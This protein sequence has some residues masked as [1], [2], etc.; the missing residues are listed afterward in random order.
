MARVIQP[1]LGKGAWLWQWPY[2]SVAAA[3]GLEAP[4]AQ[5]LGQRPKPELGSNHGFRPSPAKGRQM[6]ATAPTIEKT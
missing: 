4:S 2:H 5:G 1:M 6:F 3:S